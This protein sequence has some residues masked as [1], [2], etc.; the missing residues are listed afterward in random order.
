MIAALTA[1]VRNGRWQSPYQECIILIP[2]AH[3]LSRGLRRCLNEILAFDGDSS[4]RWNAWRRSANESRF[5]S[6]SD[7]SLRSDRCPIR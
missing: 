2:G 5:G 1:A 4:P 7:G 3:R 6:F